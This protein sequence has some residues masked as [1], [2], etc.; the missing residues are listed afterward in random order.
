M[1]VQE[2][3]QFLDIGQRHLG[4]G[5]SADLAH[6]L[7]GHAN[8]PLGQHLKGGPSDLKILV[9]NGIQDVPGGHPLGGG[10]ST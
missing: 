8:L 3:H 10:R 9:S 5:G 4:R 2:I 1:A 7:L 6:Q